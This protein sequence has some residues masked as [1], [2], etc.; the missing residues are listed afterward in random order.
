MKLGFLPVEATPLGKHGVEPIAHVHATDFL[1]VYHAL[2]T[3]TDTVPE[4]P[5][6]VHSA[7]DD[8]RKLSLVSCFNRIV[9]SHDLPAIA[10]FAS[11]RTSASRG[12]SCPVCRASRAF[13]F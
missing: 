3:H 4:V 9:A 10:T 13:V 1:S 7:F 12:V 11:C 5:G 6:G 2:S 8:T